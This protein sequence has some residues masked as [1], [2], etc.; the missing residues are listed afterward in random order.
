MNALAWKIKNLPTRLRGWKA[1]VYT[2]LGFGVCTQLTAVHITKDGVRTD[3]GVVSRRVVTD[4]GVAYLV[5]ALQNL[6]EPEN[7]N[8][9]DC[10]TGTGAEA[11][12]DSALG[13]P[14]GGSRQAGTQTEPASNQYRS[15]ATISFS[16][17]FAITEHGLFS[18]AAAG[19]L[20]D[21]SKFTAIN[22]VSGDSIQF[23]YTLTINSG[24]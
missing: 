18:A 21:R 12:S 9:H 15:T 8:Y 5:D 1:E 6:T 10:G 2:A 17:T 13:T 22:V 24:G 3:L 14:Y 16:G 11:A 4:N 7:L 19:T 20:F 23:Q